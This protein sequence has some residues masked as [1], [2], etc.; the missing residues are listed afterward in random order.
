MKT[1]KL[2]DLARFILDQEDDAPVDFHNN[3]N[4]EKCGCLLVQYGN[5]IGMEF[6]GCTM[7]G[8]V[9]KGGL[10]LETE[11]DRGLFYS[12]CPNGNINVDNFGALKPAAKKLLDNTSQQAIITVE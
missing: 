4:N 8:W 10:L 2:E 7:N 1:I 6:Y 9:N 12:F 3:R 5:S 11:L